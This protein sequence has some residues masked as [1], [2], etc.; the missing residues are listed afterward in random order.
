M[1][2]LVG[3][4][5]TLTVLSTIPSLAQTLWLD[6]LDL[7]AMEIGWGTPGVRKSVEGHQLSIAGQKFGHGVGTHAVSTFMIKLDRKGKRFSAY[8][9][10]DDET[11]EKASVRF[12]VLGDRKVLWDSEV[13]KK[14]SIA[15]K[16]DLDVRNIN[17]LGLL[18]TDADDG[19]DYD[20]ADWCDAKIEMI[21]PRTQRQLAVP[22]LRVKPY[23]LTP[24]ASEK[25]RI[26]GAMVFGVRPG[27]P[28]LY[29]IAAT[30]KRPMKFEAN[31]LPKG[32]VVD[33]SS[34]RIT[35]V[36]DKRGDYTVTL[37]AKNAIG[38]AGQ[39]LLIIAG[40]NICLTPPMGW[41]SWNCWAEAVDDAKVRAAADAMATSGLINHGWTYINIDDCWMVK[42]DTSKNE[43]KP[44][45]RDVKGMI[46]S[47][48]KFPDMNALSEYVHD[49]GLKLG[50]YSG[51]GPLTC[52]GY[53]AS[54]RHEEQDAKRFG[55]WG[56]DYLKY[57]WCS[58]SQV[59]K[60]RS[61]PELKKP[62]AVM[63]A[64]LDSVRR[65]I[66]Y[67]LCQYG[68]GNVWEWGAELGGNCW[69]TTGD[70]NDTWSSM[71]G[72]GFTQAGHEE[73]AAP[74]H[75][76]DPDMLVVGL[77]GWGP[78]LHPTRL[79]PDEQYTHISLWCLL[80]A[81][82]LIGCDMSK[83]DDFT[84]NLLTN[85]EVLAINQD[86]LGRQ[87]V[88]LSNDKGR[89][90][91]VKDMEDGSKA[92]GLFNT[93]EGKRAPVD[94]FNVWS[95]RDRALMTLRSTDLGFNGRFKVRDVWRQKNLGVFDGKVIVEVPY[96]GVAL[97]RVWKK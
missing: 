30:G 67:S 26:N 7:S 74:G 81:P 45:P 29:T 33:S 44:E 83:L 39:H 90:I 2:S 6:E 59:A 96:H 49:K 32:L 43:L 86:P 22:L 47:N 8:A 35:G 34:G 46:K 37:V 85:D 18:V 82:L 79:T 61:L 65:D 13:M 76:N 14:D 55:E 53:T 20:H 50:I 64:A 69:R 71:A 62:Y 17:I 12:Y 84:L 63:R 42:P 97:V 92:V 24:I 23:I 80:S 73:F 36:L 88:R 48:N 54:Y 68:M 94:Y 40:D 28:F 4:I 89:Q 77:V 31:N 95:K 3:V 60:D 66:V 11:R 41:N 75:W 10:V 25:P 56:I 51:P 19:I 93:D 87:A 91:W 21:S 57:D 16:V 52:A 58:Y 70:I 9:G 38:K 5:L 27:N 15:K 72:I 78:Q 1:K